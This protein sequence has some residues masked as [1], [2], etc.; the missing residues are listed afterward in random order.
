M[1]TN[2]TNLTTINGLSDIIIFNNSVTDDLF[3]ILFV[4]KN[5]KFV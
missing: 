4:Y 1:V 5:F 3:S 2:L